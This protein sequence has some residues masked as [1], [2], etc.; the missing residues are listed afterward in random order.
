MSIALRQAIENDSS[1][2]E[3]YSLSSCSSIDDA[4]TFLGHCFKAP[5]EF[6]ASTK[7]IPKVTLVVGAGKGDRAKFD[8]DLPK[9]VTQVLRD[10]NYT[11]DKSATAVPSCAGTYKY[12]HD[13][14]KNE[15][16]VHVFPLVNFKAAQAEEDGAE[17][18][19]E[20]TGEE[21]AKWMCLVSSMDTFKP[22]VD[23]KL[24]TWSCKRKLVAY[25]K[26]QQA[27][28]EK[29]EDKLTNRFSLTPEEQKLFDNA[30]KS[31]IEE[32]MGFLRSEMVK[33]VENNKL[34]KQE[35]KLALEQMQSRLKEAE[36]GGNKGA[37]SSLSKRISALEEQLE[38]KSY[39]EPLKYGSKLKQLWGKSLPLEKLQ[40]KAGKCSAVMISQTS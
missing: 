9:W 7:T 8:E 31:L 17:E 25:L 16:F 24:G 5:L 11:E 20:V 30:D 40:E 1:A 26:D 38:E 4:K 18:E 19:A 36:A 35:R 21:K 6:E 29:I 10:L 37:V 3:R 32:K 2:V 34:T 14:G 33:H 15:K 22:M 13:T 28:I 12:Q 39:F 23:G 27:E